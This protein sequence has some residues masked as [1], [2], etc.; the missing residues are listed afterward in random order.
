MVTTVAVK[1]GSLAGAT[2][3]NGWQMRL[4]VFGFNSRNAVGN[5]GIWSVPSRMV[6]PNICD[7]VP[8]MEAGR[9]EQ[10]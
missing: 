10:P 9:Y 2:R 8:S 6:F 5:L 7:A 4:R 1:S 3:D